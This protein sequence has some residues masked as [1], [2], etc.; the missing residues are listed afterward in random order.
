VKERSH[1]SVELCFEVQDTGIGFTE[2]QRRRLFQSFSQVD[3]ST[4]RKYGGTGLGLAISKRLVELMGGQIDGSSV[5]GEGS[6]FW[7]TARLQVEA[8]DRKAIAQYD[9][10][11]GLRVLVVDDNPINQEILSGVLANWGMSV[12][13]AGDGE[14]ALACLEAAVQARNPFTLALVDFHMPACDGIELAAEIKAR[15]AIAGTMLILL[16]SIVRLRSDEEIAAAGFQSYLMKPI[17]QSALFDAIIAAVIGADAGD[18][19]RERQQRCP[20]I[21]SAVVPVFRPGL[22]LLLAEDNEINRM[23]FQ[24]MLSTFG[25]HCELVENGAEALQAARKGRYD[26]IFIDCQ[27]PVMDGYTATRELRQYEADAGVTHPTVVI[28]LTANAMASDR[29]QCLAAGMNDYISK[30]LQSDVL[31]SVLTRWGTDGAGE[32]YAPAERNEEAAPATGA[33]VPASTALDP[34]MTALAEALPVN[35]QHLLRRCAGKETFALRMLAQFIERSGDEV[36]EIEAAIERQDSVAVKAL[37]HRIKGAAATLA[38]EQ[39]RRCAAQI[40]ECGKQAD[41][42]HARMCLGEFSDRL[43]ELHAFVEN[44]HGEVQAGLPS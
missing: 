9:R 30:P 17:R 16:T 15:P 10:L 20:A 39:L 31:L 37:A 24:E 43:G 8:A 41:F 32:D 7:F 12:E 3:P 44:Y 29:E 23:V 2:E 27:M 6:T 5:P 13:I 21:T 34:E 25:L 35:M 28:A 22:R 1:P 19:P 4:T 38:A 26:I 42:D 36:D 11:K 14:E 40:E 33:E 18:K